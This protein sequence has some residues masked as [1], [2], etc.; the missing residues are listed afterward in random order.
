MIDYDVGDVVVCVKYKPH[1]QSPMPHVP[2]GSIHRVVNLEEYDDGEKFI[3]VDIEGHWHPDWTYEATSFRK[4]P[5]ADP[6][7][8]ALIKRVVQPKKEVMP[9]DA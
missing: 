9:A 6:D 3:G 1:P 2:L 8:T 4:L 5:K 7:F